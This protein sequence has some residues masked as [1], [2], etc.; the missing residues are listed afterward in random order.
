MWQVEDA[1]VVMKLYQLRRIEWERSLKSKSSLHSKREAPRSDRKVS[2]WEVM[3]LAR[4]K[5]GK[6]KMKD[7]RKEAREELLLNADKKSKKT[8]QDSK[9]FHVM[10][11]YDV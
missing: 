8:K 2:R 9:P 3:R 5:R 4:R 11:D 6:L 10:L 1:R 7:K